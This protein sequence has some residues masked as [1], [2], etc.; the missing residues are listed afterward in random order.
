MR[1]P[2]LSSDDQLLARLHPDLSDGIE[3]LAYWHDRR[4]RLSWYRIGARR[5]A[6]RMVLRWE[7]RVR[8]AMFSRSAV[9]IAARLSAGM[10]LTRTHMRRWRRRAAISLTLIA[11]AAIVVAPAVVA[12][13]LLIRVV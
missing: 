5:E 9:P 1:K 6:A 12:V 8:D 10:L 2:P 4:S 13:L 7:D 11:G 3:S